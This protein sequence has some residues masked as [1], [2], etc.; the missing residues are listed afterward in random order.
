[1]AEYAEHTKIS[2][3][4][5]VYALSREESEW[6]VA[7]GKLFLAFCNLMETGCEKKAPFNSLLGLLQVFYLLPQ[8]FLKLSFAEQ[9]V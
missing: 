3:V 4:P 5:R 8:F 7:S 2:S 6:K 1:M 9:D